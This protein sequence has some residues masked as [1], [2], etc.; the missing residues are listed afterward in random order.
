MRSGI[1]RCHARVEST[2]RAACPD[3]LCTDPVLG[4]LD[5]PIEVARFLNRSPSTLSGQLYDRPPDSI[6]SSEEP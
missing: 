4:R 5:R 2:C 3:W 1:A 6:V